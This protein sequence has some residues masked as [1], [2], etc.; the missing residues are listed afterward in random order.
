MQ[1]DLSTSQAVVCQQWRW[2]YYRC[3]ATLECPQ[4]HRQMAQLRL[5]LQR[6]EPQEWTD[7]VRILLFLECYWILLEGAWLHRCRAEV[8][9]D[10]FHVA[11]KAQLDLQN[12]LMKRWQQWHRQQNDWDHTLAVLEK[13][14]WFEEQHRRLLST[15]WFQCRSHS[16][17]AALL[18]L[19][20]Q[21]STWIHPKTIPSLKQSE[22]SF[23]QSFA[24]IRQ[25]LLRYQ[26]CHQ[27]FSFQFYLDR[28]SLFDQLAKMNP[29]ETRSDLHQAF[30]VQKPFWQWLQAQPWSVD[31]SVNDAWIYLEGWP[32]ADILRTLNQ[33]VSHALR[34][35]FPLLALWIEQNKAHWQPITGS[36]SSHPMNYVFATPITLH[37]VWHSEGTTGFYWLGWLEELVQSWLTQQGLGGVKS[38]N[39][40]VLK[41]LVNSVIYSWLTALSQHSQ[42]CPFLKRMTHNVWRYLIYWLPESLSVNKFWMDS[43]TGTSIQSI[44]QLDKLWLSIRDVYGLEKRICPWQSLLFH[45]DG[46]LH[47]EKELFKGQDLLM[48][49][50]LYL[51]SQQS[52]D[53]QAMLLAWLHTPETPLDPTYQWTDPELWHQLVHQWVYHL[54]TLPTSE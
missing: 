34:D 44:A 10:R 27:T 8:N 4:L 22:A 51:E 45:L 15:K 21:C 53:P 17:W 26:K 50:H 14:D 13:L 9:E 25:C 35:D 52:S 54:M 30:M 29:I 7:Q 48:G 28:M 43:M 6:L 2:P 38:G 32:V 12:L 47:F 11:I 49:L 39:Q 18:P 20:R 19:M 37:Y 5:V 23:E 33:S 16:T 40:R 24:A 3:S 41:A 42:T 31:H 46:Q 1:T 36:V